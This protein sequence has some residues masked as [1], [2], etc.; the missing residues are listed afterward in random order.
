[1]SK[2]GDKTA[3]NKLRVALVFILLPSVVQP[4]AAQT[5]AELSRHKVVSVISVKAS[6]Q[7]LFQGYHQWMVRHPQAVPQAPKPVPLQGFPVGSSQTSSQFPSVNPESLQ[8][9][10]KPDSE[11][12][13]DRPPLLIRTPSVDLY[14]PS[15][16]SLYHGTKS[17]E[18]AAFIRA[19]P[20]GIQEGKTKKTNEIRPT[21]QE[22]MGMFPEFDPYKSMPTGKNLSTVFVLAFP[23][24]VDCKA[25][26]GAIQELKSRAH[27]LGIRVIEVRIHR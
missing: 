24:L 3:L 25:Q 5:Q 8:G 4:N 12:S 16:V 2:L 1:M 10:A 17:E 7:E 15:G 20:L 11:R 13:N 19:L 6:V 9:I 22:A 18:N 21:L 14:S 27:G 23:D 26:D